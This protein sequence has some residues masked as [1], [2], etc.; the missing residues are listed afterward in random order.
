MYN[1]TRHR[2]V[3]A[4]CFLCVAVAGSALAGSRDR[5]HRDWDRDHRDWNW[6]W[7]GDW[8]RDWDRDHRD[9]R[10]CDED[11]DHHRN[12]EKGI[13]DLRTN[14]GA[15]GAIASVAGLSGATDS[16]EVTFAK[17][18]HPGNFGMGVNF[19]KA[20][21][22]AWNADNTVLTISGGIDFSDADEPA[23][24]VYLMQTEAD[25]KDISEP[26][27]FKFQDIEV[28]GI[29]AGNDQ[30][31]MD[32]DVVSGDGKGYSVYI[33]KSQTGRFKRYDQVNFNSR[34]ANIRGLEN[35]EIYWVYVEYK[36]HGL[37]AT[38]T[39]PVAV[40]TPKRPGKDHH[41]GN[42]HR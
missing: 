33:A 6:K 1:N 24:I 8:G 19:A 11:R 7:G 2:M 14:Y 12:P 22:K 37:V 34:G 38:R 41:P 23:L 16:I 42:D 9:H 26:N 5:D 32:F 3:V 18:M 17:P 31:K 13:V 21:T 30:V 39:V 40:T 35:G 28:T 20:W 10:D 4:A 29:K 36:R 25:R 15:S 27:I